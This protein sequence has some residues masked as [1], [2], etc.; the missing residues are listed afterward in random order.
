MTYSL[1]LSSNIHINRIFHLSLL[2][3]LVLKR[4]SKSPETSSPPNTIASF[5]PEVSQILDYKFFGGK[6]YYLND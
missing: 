5:E 6:L 1:Q 2:L 3:P 4:F